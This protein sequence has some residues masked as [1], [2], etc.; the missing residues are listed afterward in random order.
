M[1]IFSEEN[2]VGGYRVWSLSLFLALTDLDFFIYFL[3]QFM[4]LVGFF[5][6]VQFLKWVWKE[7]SMRKGSQKVVEFGKIHVNV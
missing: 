1:L 4:K 2:E 7:F 5:F 6:F 3:V